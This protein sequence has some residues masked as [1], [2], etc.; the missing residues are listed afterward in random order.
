M[1]RREE[2]VKEE[3]RGR[4]ER[5]KARKRGRERERTK[6]A[7]VGLQEVCEYCSFFF[8]GGGDEICEDKEE[9][10]EV[11]IITIGRFSRDSHRTLKG[12]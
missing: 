3:K 2:R 4:G 10:L 8:W 11:T 12:S 5:G 7:L 1:G 6:G 9:M